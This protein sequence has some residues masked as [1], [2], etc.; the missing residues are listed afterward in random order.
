MMMNS[1]K[2]TALIT[3]A[4]SGIGKALAQKFA[5]EGFT[6]VLVARD[7]QK[8]TL[9]ADT[10]H[11]Q[12]GTHSHIVALDL[13][14]PDST[15]A[16]LKAVEALEIDVLV[17]NAGFGVHGAFLETDLLR[18]QELVELQIQSFL[19]I[20]KGLLKKMVR[21]R[22]GRILNIASVYASVPV[23]FQAVYGASKAFMLSFSQALA[24]EVKPHGIQITVSCPGSTRTEFRKRIGIKE[25]EGGSGMSADVVAGDAYRALMRGQAVVTSGWLNFFV[26]EFLRHMSG[27]FAAKA[28]IKINQFRGVNTQH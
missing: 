20:T 16:L 3:G 14:Q 26:I 8:L 5:K 15:T 13:C 11:S 28:M 6:V 1:S 7:T 9:L 18:E 27:S 25:K 10:L 17:N 21:R 4:S 19:G 22:Q 23:P 2:L 24:Q 12:Y